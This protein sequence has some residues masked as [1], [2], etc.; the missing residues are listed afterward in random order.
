MT[1]DCPECGNH[2]PYTVYSC[3]IC[4]HIYRNSL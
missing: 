2:N 1:W 4:N 3:R